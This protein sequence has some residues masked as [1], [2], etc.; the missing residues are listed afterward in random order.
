M[1]CAHMCLGESPS[2]LVCLLIRT[3]ILSDWALSLFFKK[4]FIYLAAPDLSCNMEDLN[5]VMQTL[6]YSMWDLVP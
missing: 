5:C 1:P 3:P 6:C 4:I 2:S